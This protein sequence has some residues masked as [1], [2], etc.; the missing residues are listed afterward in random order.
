MTRPT[1]NVC[2]DVSCW[3]NDL[4]KVVSVGTSPA[5]QMLT[6]QLQMQMQR[7]HSKR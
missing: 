5:N 4:L 1:R 2:G 6:L 7:K 3:L